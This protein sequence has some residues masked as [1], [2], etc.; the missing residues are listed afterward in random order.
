MRTYDEAAQPR[1]SRRSRLT[2]GLRLQP[3]LPIPMGVTFW[4]SST[5]ISSSSMA[6]M[7][8]L[9]WTSSREVSPSLMKASSYFIRNLQNLIHSR[10]YQTCGAPPL[11]C[12]AGS[13]ARM[14]LE[15][16]GEDQVAHRQR[17]I[18]RLCRAAAGVAQRS[19][20]G[21]ADLALPSRGRVQAQWQIEPHDGGPERLVLG[22]VV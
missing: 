9:A 5:S 14:T 3:F 2:Q 4:G 1:Q 12:R 16:A 15:H 8:R 22:L 21:P 7:G 20:T 19:G 6:S 17:R 11:R 18:E 10:S 13:Q